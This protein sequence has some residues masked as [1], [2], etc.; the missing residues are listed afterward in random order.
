MCPPAPAS[1]GRCARA[2]SP[3]P[4]P[5]P[6]RSGRPA[7][8]SRS[9]RSV[10]T[11]CAIAWPCGPSVLWR[12]DASG[13]FSR[14]WT[15]T[16][17]CGSSASLTAS[18]NGRPVARAPAAPS[19]PRAGQRRRAA[20]PAPSRRSSSAAGGQRPAT[21]ARRRC[22]PTLIVTPR[23]VERAQRGVERA[24]SGSADVPRHDRDFDQRR[25]RAA[26]SANS[27]AC[28]DHAASASAGI[29]ST[30]PAA[31]AGS[32]IRRAFEPACRADRP[33][34]ARGRAVGRLQIEGVELQR[35]AARSRWHRGQ[36]G[37]RPAT[38]AVS[39]GARPRARERP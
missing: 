29:A 5:A 6:G 3:S 15:G 21:R 19:G 39:V 27:R 24:G 11:A 18:A 7:G 31:D 8:R 32:A 28:R 14:P 2:A 17:F 16:G 22:P 35:R 25:S 13:A 12:C 23:A 26:P 36:R 9:G 38:A 1:S 20:S 37:V 4:R 34:A 30:S 10:S 33:G